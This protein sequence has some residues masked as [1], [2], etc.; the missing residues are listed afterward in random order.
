MKEL[1]MGFGPVYRL[2]G[3]REGNGSNRVWMR[4]GWVPEGPSLGMEG[5]MGGTG[6]RNVPEECMLRCP[7][8]GVQ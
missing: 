6:L 3:L 7:Q 4:E 5:C 2:G 8:M 1:P